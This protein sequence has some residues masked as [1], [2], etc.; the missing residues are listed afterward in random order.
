M[1]SWT[2]LQNKSHRR[3]R[4]AEMLYYLRMMQ[5]LC[6]DWMGMGMDGEGGEDAGGEKVSKLAPASADWSS[7]FLRW[8][9]CRRECLW[10]IYTED[11]LVLV[12]L[13]V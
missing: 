9:K 4:S 10:N 5:Y 7:Y 13:C 11:S 8:G 6:V 12:T 3:K 2:I 1:A